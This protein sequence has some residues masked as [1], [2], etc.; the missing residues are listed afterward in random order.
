MITFYV[1]D[2]KYNNDIYSLA[3][4]FYPSSNVTVIAVDTIKDDL[5]NNHKKEK[6]D[7]DIVIL[8]SL[9]NSDIELNA[10]SA[11]NKEQAIE[12]VYSIKEKVDY[13]DKRYYRN[14]LKRLVYN[15]LKKISKKD[16]KWGS[17]TG[18]RP[19]KIVL[20]K[21]EKK[22]SK[23][24]I[25]SYMKE[26]Y[27]C[28]D[29]KINLC[30]EIAEKELELLEKVDYKNGYSLYIGIPFCPSTCLYC[31]FASYSIDKFQDKVE[32]YLKALMKEI[33]YAASYMANKKLLTI[34]IGGGTPTALNEEQLEKLLN[35][36]ESVIDFSYVY[37]YSVEAGRP[38][39]ITLE[40]LKLLK[41]YKVGR[42]SINPQSM[43]QKTLDL[44]GRKHTV[45]EVNQMFKLARE[46]GHDNINMDIIIGLPGEDTSDVLHTLREIDKLQPDSLTVHALA[47]KRA[48]R[49]NIQ[50]EE[51]K[52]LKPYDISLMKELTEQY[53]IAAGYLPYYLYRQKNV[54]DNIENIGYAKAGKEGLY[55]VLMMEDKHNILAVGAG[56]LSKFVFYEQE[57]IRRVENV[58]SL[59][60]YIERIDEMI[61][62]KEQFKEEYL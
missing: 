16:L 41:K 45:E 31:S 10:F 24:D 26:Q 35:H 36:I 15:S 13:A 57:K 14:T 2:K 34:Y 23:A 54:A 22:E 33:S 59:N 38:D 5:I 53:A 61:E 46:T 1:N 39:S 9:N 29:E 32:A 55:N 49:L 3:R 56:A 52:E 8:A 11:L 47:I 7:F 37:E 48:A 17:L 27:Y 25:I 58:K 51:Y 62:R 43:S 6:D 60:D 4:A 18:V 20:D 21:L 30:M 12:K 40:K 42:I 44:I 50:M 28:T 19:S